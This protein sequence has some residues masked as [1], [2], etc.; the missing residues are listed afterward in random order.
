M[1]VA[2]LGDEAGE[3]FAKLHDIRGARL[4]GGAVVEIRNAECGAAAQRMKVAIAVSGTTPV[5]VPVRPQG[6]QEGGFAALELPEHGDLQTLSASR[7][8]K[9][10]S[11][12]A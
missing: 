8:R 7:S 10:A 11:K 9:A 12:I 1:G 6:L 4:S 5:G 2:L 3:L